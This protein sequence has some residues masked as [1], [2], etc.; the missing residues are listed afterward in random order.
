M[1]KIYA[2]TEAA[3]HIA[4]ILPVG[5]A[6]S[7]SIYLAFSSTLELTFELG[8]ALRR[9]LELSSLSLASSPSLALSPLP[10]PA[11]G[12]AHL[13]ISRSLARS[14]YS[15]TSLHR[16]DH[17]RCEDHSSAAVVVS[18]PSNPPNC[19]EADTTRGISSRA[20][21][22][23]QP[24]I[25]VAE[26]LRRRLDSNSALTKGLRVIIMY[27]YQIIFP[28]SSASHRFRLYV[29][30][31]LPAR[32]AA[33]LCCTTQLHKCLLVLLVDCCPHFAGSAARYYSA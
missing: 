5:Q 15:L 24:V 31:Q 1:R 9:N 23:S 3:P 7:P 4:E 20:G 25:W 8:R 19:P 33:Q 27:I 16:C 22:C 2:P 26:E 18:L 28:G 21:G 6:L 11:R 32:L 30:A 12:R 10:S 13:S 29:T 14:L 17:A